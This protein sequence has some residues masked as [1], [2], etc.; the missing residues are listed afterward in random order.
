[1][2]ENSS[3]EKSP[4]PLVEEEDR[5]TKKAHFRDEKDTATEALPYAS[6]KDKLM[7]STLAREA[8]LNGGTLDIEMG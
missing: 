7:Q 2:T 8:D 5:S 4:P 1:M 6:F 3:F